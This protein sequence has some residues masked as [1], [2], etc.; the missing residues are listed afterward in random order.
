VNIIEWAGPLAVAVIAL[1]Q[2]WAVGF[3]NRFIRKAEID[4]YE[5]GTVEVGYSS[6][7]ATVGLQGVLRAVH[8]DQF[9]RDIDLKVVRERDGSTHRFEWAAFRAPSIATDGS[10]AR[11]ETPAGFMLTTASPY[12]YN[13][14]FYDRELFNEAQG[15]SQAL[16]P[17][18][19]AALLEAFGGAIPTGVDAA[20]LREVADEVYEEFSRQELHVGAYTGLDRL[21]YWE[22]GSFSL[23]M[24][25]NTARPTR[26]FTRRWKF[27]L[28][29]QDAA[30]LRGNTILI[31]QLICGQFTGQFNF[32][33]A[34]YEE[35]PD[36]MWGDRR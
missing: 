35:V 3:W 33:F 7:G 6:L 34:Q 26:T 14:Q 24:N 32:A 18:W 27:G 15:L 21:C 12:R 11:L 29:A 36:G 10:Q 22:A 16:Y 30:T 25:V 13:I 1:A 8:R 4:P 28:S 23:E 19:Q 20:H 5:T 31:V 2:P 17:A 9:I